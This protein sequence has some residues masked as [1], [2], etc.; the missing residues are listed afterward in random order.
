MSS[1]LASSFT[2]SGLVGLGQFL[3]WE[4][5][6]QLSTDILHTICEHDCWNHPQTTIGAV[7][8][9]KIPEFDAL[10]LVRFLLFSASQ[11]I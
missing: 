1:E 4:L 7:M 2:Q 8:K 9:T 10:G 11:H 5:A 6:K 3:L